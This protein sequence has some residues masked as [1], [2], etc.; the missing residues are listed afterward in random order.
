MSVQINGQNGFSLVELLIALTIF[1]RGLL[2]VAGMQITAMKES[3]TSHLRTAAGSVAQGVLE[4]ILARDPGDPF[5][6][7]GTDDW[8]FD[9]DTAEIDST[10]PDGMGTYSATYTI[11]TSDPVNKLSR[12]VVTATGQGRTV[13]LTGFKR[14]L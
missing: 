8:D 6:V 2:G 1:A 4:E 10:N 7:A 3:N 12:I 11:T 5:F 14:I 13:V 9:P